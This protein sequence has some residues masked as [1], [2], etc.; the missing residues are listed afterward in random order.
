MAEGEIVAAAEAEAVKQGFTMC[1]AIVDDGGHLLC[2]A[3]FDETQ[4]GSIE[5]AI[6]KAR[7][8]LLFKRPT[9]L[10]QDRL[11]VDH[12]MPMLGLPT[13]VPLAGGLPLIAGGAILGAIGV[14]GSAP[15]Q[16]VHV[17]HRVYRMPFLSKDHGSRRT[18][19]QGGEQNLPHQE[20]R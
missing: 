11:T 18:G 4:L 14:S 7:T 15:Q 17:Q 3:R 1:I 9:K 19:L 13:S 10:F 2:F 5:V 12:W 6:A 16:D 8:A 20:R